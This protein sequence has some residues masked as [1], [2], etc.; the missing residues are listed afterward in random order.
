MQLVIMRH[1]KAQPDA[2]E[3]DFRR[4]LVERGE[5]DSANVG[6]QLA[7]AKL[8][9]TRVVASPSTR[10]RETLA[11]A[12]PASTAD[13]RVQWEEGLYNGDLQQLMAAVGD[14]DNE[15]RLWLIGHNPGVSALLQFLLPDGRSPVGSMRP[16]EA[17]VLSIER[18][19]RDKAQLV[20]YM[21]PQRD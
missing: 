7:D 15:G 6:R 2:P 10:T 12:L 11:A 5:R 18:M 13:V 3:G 8:L 9:P 20:A 17:A 16:G 4:R 21:R 1:G 19:E 14:A